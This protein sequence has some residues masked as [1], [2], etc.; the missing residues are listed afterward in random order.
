VKHARFALCLLM[1]LGAVATRGSQ[2]PASASA[3]PLAELAR[4][5]AKWHA[6]KTEAYEF[7]FQ[8]ACNGLIQPPLPDVPP[9]ILIRVKDGESTY[10]DTPGA[11]PVPVAAEL[12]QY[13]TVEKL[14][15]LIRKAWAARP[16]DPEPGDVMRFNF[17]RFRI[18]VQYD[19]LRGYPTR[20]CV[21]TDTTVSDNEFGFLITDFKVLSKAGLER[22][23]GVPQ[24][25]TRPQASASIVAS[26][27]CL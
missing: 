16:S 27:V 12:V 5:E 18:D 25:L 15:A 7:R 23:G 10:L 24:V 4:A 6:S 2:H 19:P 20:L 9:G 22:N 3:E 1:C 8:S 26:P 17:P 14:F 11:V 21:D 13:S